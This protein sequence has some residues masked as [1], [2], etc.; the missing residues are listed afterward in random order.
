M[1]LRR[2]LVV[3]SILI[4]AAPTVSAA[5]KKST[6]PNVGASKSYGTDKYVEEFYRDMTRYTAQAKAVGIAAKAVPSVPIS[7]S[8]S[9][10]AMMKTIAE[11]AV[12]TVIITQAAQAQNK[13]AARLNDW[14]EAQDL[15]YGRIKMTQTFAQK[16]DNTLK[17]S[18]ARRA[19]KP[20]KAFKQMSSQH[21]YNAY[22]GGVGDTGNFTRMTTPNSQGAQAAAIAPDSGN[23]VDDASGLSGTSSLNG[24]RMVGNSTS[25]DKNPALNPDADKLSVYKSDVAQKTFERMQ[26]EMEDKK[27]RAEELRQEREQQKQQQQQMMMQMAQQAAQMASQAAQQG[28]AEG[29]GGGG[30][31]NIQNTSQQFQSAAEASQGQV[32]T[33]SEEKAAES[34]AAPAA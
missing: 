33:S 14:N 25:G 2:L 32:E 23:S 4:L 18:A 24:S 34:E 31:S 11:G 9:I 27:A 17:G 30:C 7:K 20:R 3:I 28:G 21:S 19:A 22:G 29:G 1:V 8:A 13:M 15:E 10:M 16:K 6:I 5:K 12:L 26:K